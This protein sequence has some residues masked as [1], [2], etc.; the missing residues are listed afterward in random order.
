MFGDPRGLRLVRA[1]SVPPWDL[2]MPLRFLRGSWR[3]LALTVAGLACGVALVC[4]PSG[5]GKSTLLNLVAGLDTPSGG[6]VWVA[7][8]DLGA[9]SEDAL[10]DLRLALLRSP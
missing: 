5:S 8:E 2:R 3:R 10:S 1:G 6:R 4:G 7:G 9:L